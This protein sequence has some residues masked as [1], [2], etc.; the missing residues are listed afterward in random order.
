MKR[1]ISNPPSVFTFATVPT[2]V[3]PVPNSMRPKVRELVGWH[4]SG[5]LNDGRKF[6]HY[7]FKRPDLDSYI[8]IT[9]SGEGDQQ[10]IYRVRI[11]KQNDGNEIHQ[12]F[13]NDVELLEEP[14]IQAAK[15]IFNEIYGVE[16]PYS[17]MYQGD[18]C[19]IYKNK[20]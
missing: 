20:K 19:P 2:D 15:K 4:E 8:K 10:D 9:S 5:T 11:L 7:Y 6:D 14:D 17:S 1:N 12:I 13:K 3:K 16:R 18:D